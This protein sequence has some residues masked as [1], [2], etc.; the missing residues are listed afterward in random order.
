MKAP[1]SVDTAGLL[2]LLGSRDWNG[3]GSALSLLDRSQYDTE[4]WFCEALWLANRPQNPDL[5]AAIDAISQACHG[6]SSNAKYTVV[7]AELLLK[8]GR[9]SDAV[10]ASRNALRLDPHNA[11]AYMVLGQGQSKLSCYR[12]AAEAFRQGEQLLPSGQSVLRQKFVDLRQRNN[13]VWWE[14]IAGRNVQL[15]RLA[16]HHSD[17]FQQAFTDV[18]FQQRMNL[19]KPY[20]RK[21]FERE[22][23]RNR[24]LPQESKRIDWVVKWDN[25]YH[26]ILSYVDISTAN[27]RAEIIVGFPSNG[28]SVRKEAEATLLMLDFGFDQLQ[29]NRIYS[30]VYANNKAGQTNTLGLGFTHE[31]TLREHVIHPVS[32]EPLDLWAYGLLKRDYYR[33]ERMSK[34][35]KR[36]LGHN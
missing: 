15:E 4:A 11:F 12:E 22:V 35:R 32:G 6:D 13:P 9:F 29:L 17:F 3:L 33:N 8:A 36:L 16:E 20:S 26:G 14:P 30:Y 31:G 27:Q 10:E 28:V 5:M 19:F 25:S 21:R 34:L 23:Q 7:K 2:A 1:S 18:A 24:Q